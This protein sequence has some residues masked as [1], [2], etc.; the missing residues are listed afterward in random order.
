MDIIHEKILYIFISVKISW[1]RIY[2][3]SGSSQKVYFFIGSD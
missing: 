2:V 1:I 3:E